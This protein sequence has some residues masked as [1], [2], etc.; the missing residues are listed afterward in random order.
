M[1]RGQANLKFLTDRRERLRIELEAAKARLEEVE[2]LI[3]QMSGEAIVLP[4]AEV[5]PRR[6]GLKEVV[7]ELYEEAGE[8][9]LTTTECVEAAAKRGVTLQPPSVSSTLSRFKGEGV[10]MYDGERYRL[11]KFAGRGARQYDQKTPRGNRPKA[12]LYQ[13]VTW[14]VRLKGNRWIGAGKPL[15]PG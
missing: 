13:C 6:G 2:S 1:S 4:L 14:K 11:K 8:L 10:L 12:P 3:R 5:R 15:F 7:L 9:G